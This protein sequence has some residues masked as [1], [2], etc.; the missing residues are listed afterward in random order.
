MTKLKQFDWFYLALAVFMVS[1][2]FSEALISIS[3][4]L[5]LIVSLFQIKKETLFQKLSSRKELILF[6]SVYLVYL[7]GFLFN[8]DRKWGLYDLQKNI[9][10]LIIP[11]AFLFGNQISKRQVS[12]LLKLF[13]LAVFSSAV[14]TMIGFY[15]KDERTVLSAQEFGFIHHIRFSFQIVFSIIIL[16]VFLLTNQFRINNIGKFAFVLVLLFLVLFLIWHQSFT[17]LMTFLGTAFIGLILLAS[18]FKSKLKKSLAIMGLVF[19]VLIPAAYLYY[20]VHEFYTIDQVDF[21]NL[22]KKTNLG[23]SYTQHFDNLQLENGHYIGLY[24][25]ESEM[26]EAWNKRSRM[27][28]EEQDQNGYQVKATLIRY[29]TSKDLRKDASGVNQLSDED[30]QNIEAGISNYILADKGLSLYPRIYVS[31]WEL[32][33][34]FKT[35]DANRQSLSQRIEYAKAALSIIKEHFWFGVGTGNWKKAYKEAYQ[36]IHSKMAPAR[37]GDAHN[38]YLNYMVKFGL[39]GLLWILFVFIYPVVKTK[40]YRNPIFFLFLVSMLIANFGDS[41]FETHVGSSYFVLMYCLF[42]STKNWS[43]NLKKELSQ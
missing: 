17:G 8:T 42:I 11:F 40:S 27:K 28:Y 43:M 19:L 7:I 25:C 35:G 13:A 30:I 29:L 6:S 41:N 10:Y 34:Y 26:R 14:I 22:D 16:S 38:Q 9:P 33:K 18:H 37:Y 5:L 4:V 23:N 39:V 21:N 31:I 24:W 20:A 36:K 32:D 15:M 3:G 12:N 2:P 1:L